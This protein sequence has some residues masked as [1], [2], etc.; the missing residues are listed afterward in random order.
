MAAYLLDAMRQREG[1]LAA[2]WLTLAAVN[3]FLITS[4]SIDH[5]SRPLLLCLM[6]LGLCSGVLFVAGC[7]ATLQFRWV[8][9]Q[10][11]PVVM[12][13]ER[14]VLAGSVTVGGPMIAWGAVAAI[15]A[16]SAPYY[17]AFI[18]S[19]LY[20]LLAV[21]MP[22][23]FHS[24]DFGKGGGQASKS[25]QDFAVLVGDNWSCAFPWLPMY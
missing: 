25:P 17:F 12:A 16:A 24:K 9:M 18:V 1:S 10:Y 8:Q 21:P 4:S 13:L 2:V 7:W 11:P 20:L 5:G 19:C 15:G 22:S 3:L 14:M 23:S 6:A